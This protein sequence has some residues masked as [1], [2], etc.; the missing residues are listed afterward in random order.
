MQ[1]NDSLLSNITSNG[2]RF[3]MATTLKRNLWPSIP[4]LSDDS[5]SR[6]TKHALV[7]FATQTLE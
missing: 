5:A 2:L 4:K 7:T 3:T 1:S 6:K